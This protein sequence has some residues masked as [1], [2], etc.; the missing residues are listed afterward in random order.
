MCNDEGLR[1][2]SK[3]HAGMMCVLQVLSL[4][5]QLSAQGHTQLMTYVM[6]QH[7]HPEST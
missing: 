2:S 7:L 3:D 5:E 1:G 6:I 4:W